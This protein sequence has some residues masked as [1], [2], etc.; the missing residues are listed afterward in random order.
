MSCGPAVAHMC[1]YTDGHRPRDRKET[2]PSPY[3]DQWFSSRTSE[4]NNY[5]LSIPPSLPRNLCHARVICDQASGSKPGPGRH[6][7]NEFALTREREPRRPPG[8][9]TAYGPHR[10]NFVPSNSPGVCG[11]P[12]DGVC[13]R[14]PRH[15]STPQSTHKPTP[16][17]H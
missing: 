4:L 7:M 15:Q 10:T 5:L 14:T 17:Y 8:L 16:D 12:S 9:R 6:Q 3:D 2:A 1:G 13:R 11:R